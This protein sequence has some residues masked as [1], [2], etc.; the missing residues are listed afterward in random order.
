[1]KR[2]E[3]GVA[4]RLFHHL[5]VLTALHQAEQDEVAR[6]IEHDEDIRELALDLVTRLTEEIRRFADKKG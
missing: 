1:M 2:G 6:L 5:V 3:G 4:W